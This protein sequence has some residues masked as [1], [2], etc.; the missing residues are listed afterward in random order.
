MRAIILAAGRGTRLAPYTDD[1]PKAMVPYRGLPL[2]HH[3]GATL[4]ACGVSE[5]VV[6]RGHR[7]DQ[8]QLPGAQY[9]VN[10]DGHNM[11]YS[12]FR[13]EDYLSGDVLISYSDL[14]YEPRLVQSLLDAPTA[15]VAV[16]VD[17]A[18]RRYYEFRSDTPESIAESLGL[19]GDSIREIGQ[20]LT[21]E[22]PLDGQYIGLLRLNDAGCSALK[23]MYRELERDYGDKRWR[24]APSFYDAYMTDAIQ[25]LIDRGVTVRGVRVEGGWL[26]F[27]SAHDYELAT[28]AT[29]TSPISS[30]FNVSTLPTLQGGH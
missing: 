14:L 25:E 21:P 2:L 3:I 13:A 30:H 19:D 22:R 29:P 16:V 23:Q 15:P 1:L 7:A 12:L 26:E 5:I 4:R 9:V 17:T 28:Q 6:V 8:V 18:W 27:D 24:N 10:R 11:L 20:Q